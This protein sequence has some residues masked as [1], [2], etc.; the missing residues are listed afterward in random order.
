MHTSQNVFLH[1]RGGDLGI[2]LK[3][4]DFIDGFE[5]RYRRS[6]AP[7]FLAVAFTSFLFSYLLVIPTGMIYSLEWVSV[8][9]HLSLSQ[10]F[11]MIFQRWI[12]L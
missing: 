8:V 4:G 5:A 12:P 11:S 9:A 3:F 1:S 2:E 10:N 7:L 6:A